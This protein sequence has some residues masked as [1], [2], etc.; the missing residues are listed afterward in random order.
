VLALPRP[1]EMR[2]YRLLAGQAERVRDLQGEWASVAVGL[3]IHGLCE[4]RAPLA[5]FERILDLWLEAHRAGCERYRGC[6]LVGASK[7]N[8]LFPNEE[9]STTRQDD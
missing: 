2:L 3:M 1:K 6:A 4:G 9:I 5:E 8:S 7:R